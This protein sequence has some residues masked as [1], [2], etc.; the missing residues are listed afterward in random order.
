M[1][2][3]EGLREALAAAEQRG[4]QVASGAVRLLLGADDLA[5]EQLAEAPLDDLRALVDE[6]WEEGRRRAAAAGSPFSCSGAGCYGCCRGE[7]AVGL[8]E[9]LDLVY[10]FSPEEL[11]VAVGRA[12]EL[13]ASGADPQVSICPVL[14]PVTKHCTAWARRPLICRAYNAVSPRDHCYPERVGPM[15][16]ATFS[17]PISVVGALVMVN[18]TFAQE[19]AGADRAAPLVDRLLAYADQRDAAKNKEIP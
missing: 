14:D 9:F 15:D 6:V 2:D 8:V 17:G 10:G 4:D 16:V 11:D 19:P 7:V 12:R 13:R 1:R 18:V 3:V 5:F